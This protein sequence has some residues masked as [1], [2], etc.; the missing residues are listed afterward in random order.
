MPG[1]PAKTRALNGKTIY[2]IDGVTYDCGWFI[3]EMSGP[4]LICDLEV[5][6]EH[7]FSGEVIKQNPRE[8]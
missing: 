7:K 5:E 3:T 8:N 4:N 1:K 6:R 2:S